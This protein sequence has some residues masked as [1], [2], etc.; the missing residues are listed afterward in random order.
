MPRLSLP[1]VMGMSIEQ[2]SVDDL[3]CAAHVQKIL[4]AMTMSW[5]KD[6]FD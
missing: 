1:R 3:A 4:I 2:P 5:M 6:D